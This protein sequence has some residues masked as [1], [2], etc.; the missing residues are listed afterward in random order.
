VFQRGD[1]LH[2]I[3]LSCSGAF[4]SSLCCP[5]SFTLRKPRPVSVHLQ[6]I[7]HNAVQSPLDAHLLFSS[8]TKS[9]QAQTRPDVGKDGFDRRHSS[10]VDQL[11]C[12]RVYLLPHLLRKGLGLLVGLSR[13]VGK[14]AGYGHVGILHALCSDQA[15]DAVSL[16]P[17]VLDGVEPVMDCIA[18]FIHPFAGRA[19]AEA[20]V[21][22][23]GEI[24]GL[25]DDG[26]GEPFG[27]FLIEPFFVSIC[28][29]VPGIAMTELG[30][31]DVCVNAVLDQHLHILFR[32]K[33][34]VPGEFGLLED[35]LFF[36]DHIEVLPGFFDHGF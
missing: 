1:R 14:L 8:Q 11:A 30:V 36:P 20:F 5:V 13:E 34:G 7:V 17:V 6:K 16:G 21:G 24:A 26:S 29:R 3:I 22:A 4:H 25:K 32:V 27:D 19:D 23:H 2:Y 28:G 35:V 33:S 12:Y 9:I 15:G 10:S 31:S 18:A